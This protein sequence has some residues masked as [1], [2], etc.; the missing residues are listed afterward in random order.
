MEVAD[1]RRPTRERLIAAAMDQIEADGEAGV[2]VDQVAQAAGV[3]KASLYH[4]FGDRDGLVVAAQAE[5]Y[6]IALRDGMDSQ[7]TAVRA[8][9]SRDEFE[10]LVRNWMLWT[11]SDAAIERRRVRVDVLGSSVSRPRLR[12]QLAQTD[13]EVCHELAEL[14]L[15][16][17]D[18]G[19]IDMPF[20]LD[21]A[22]MW[23][24]GML[25]GRYLVEHEHGAE[26]LAGWDAVATEATVRIVFGNP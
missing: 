11:F 15:I 25:N 23:W 12:E 20:D 18:K 24:F 4:F 14:M 3:T 2:R 9:R 22:A 21:A 6:R 19:W 5:R 8:C 13:R 16:A 26:R 1:D 10:E 17:H 7:T